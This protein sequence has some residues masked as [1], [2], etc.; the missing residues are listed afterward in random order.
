MP[1]HRHR[2]SN[3]SQFPI[4]APESAS[5]SLLPS[6]PWQQQP[7]QSFDMEEVFRLADEDNLDAALEMLDSAPKWMQRNEEFKLV[8][9]T[10]LMQAGDLDEAGEILREMERKNPRFAP[11]YLPLAAWYMQND[12]PAHALKAARK[13][14]S[15]KIDAE[16]S[17][18]AQAFID[19]AGEMLGFLATELDLPREK[20][21][22]ASWYNEKAQLATIDKNLSE[23][24]RATKEALK[25]APQWTSPRNNYAQSLFQLGKISEALA[26]TEQVLTTDPRN[27]HALN[28][29][30]MFHAGLWH[31]EQAG[32][33]AIRLFELADSFKDDAGEIDIIISALSMV[34]DTERL[35]QLAQRYRRKPVE[36]LLSRSWHILGVAAIHKGEFQEAKKLLEKASQD[37]S[38]VSTTL[39]EKVNGMLRQKST[40][41]RWLPMYPGLEL[42]ISDRLMREWGALVDNI[43]EYLPTPSQQRKIDAF[44][45]KH[46]ALLAALKKMLWAEEISRFGARGLALANKPEADAELLRFAFSDIGDNQSRMHA[47][48]L[49][50]DAERYSVENPIRFWDENKNEWSEVL[51]FSQSIGE[52]D[53]HVKP[54]VAPL[55]EK[56]QQA[57]DPKET[58]AFLRQAVEI[59][60]TCALAM[61]NLG[62]FLR[63]EGELEEGERL[64]RRSIEVDPS[65]TF[66]FANLGLIEAQRGNRE[67]ALELLMNV[68]KAKVIT[69]QTACVS[70]LAHAVIAIEDGRFEQAEYHLQ[71]A[72]E[73]NPDNP[74]ISRIEE[75]LQWQ[76]LFGDNNFFAS[77][78][79]DS[80]HRFHKKALKTPLT[81][82]MT[83]ESCLNQL[84]NETLAAM[85]RFWKTYGSGKKPALVNALTANILNTDIFSETM[86]ELSEK[87][88]EA[89]KSILEAGG[90]RP[91]QEFT[92]QFGDDWDESP[93]WK[94]HDPES[95][96][97]RL[98]LAGLLYA[99]TLDQQ[100]VAFIPVDARPLVK[101]LVD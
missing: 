83:L 68:N 27:V 51:L 93:W 9:V 4:S 43:D 48:M 36:T 18:Q 73:M 17:E 16:A 30:V 8:R 101:K 96:P 56:A 33:A 37:E 1:R 12:W 63:Q 71:T 84:T 13:I 75:L 76:R 34:E 24:E 91:W 44:L 40:R 70:N 38:L 47:A 65:Y 7:K 14:Q 64:I 11:L 78:Q 39:L 58:I 57:K 50:V 28:N 81:P 5:G 89:L 87:E 97:G 92:A 45:E 98:K 79:K 46:P 85:C 69:P 26:Q 20:A 100:Q 77:Y 99:G 32:K 29:L 52:V 72:K 62:A 21:E 2:P 54:A 19:A 49:L 90:W 15:A 86:Q 67:A 35:W 6:F 23:A 88:R 53:Y 42:L 59:D 55:I 31:P 3:P 61:H 22:Q 66:G 82:E 95:V 94:Y 60:P 41:L 74:A 25:I 10:I 80:A